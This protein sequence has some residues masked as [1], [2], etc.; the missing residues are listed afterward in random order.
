MAKKFKPWFKIRLPVQAFVL[1]AICLSAIV[2]AQSDTS[3]SRHSGLE[4]SWRRTEFG[5]QDSSN[6]LVDSFAPR[7]TLELIHPVIWGL[8]ILIL[9]IG[10]TIWASS[11]WDLARLF[12]DED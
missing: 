5:W 12:K 2:I 9:V 10:T 6:W 8:L 4:S 1:S 7:Q 3:S 11:E